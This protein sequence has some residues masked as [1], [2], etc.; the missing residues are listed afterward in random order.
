MFVSWI[1]TVRKPVAKTMAPQL[2]KTIKKENVSFRSLP[3]CAL[4]WSAREFSPDFFQ[5]FYSV[6]N[7]REECWFNYDITIVT[8]MLSFQAFPIEWDHNGPNIIGDSHETSDP[9]TQAVVIRL[10]PFRPNRVAYYVKILAYRARYWLLHDI[11]SPVE[12][13]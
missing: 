7:S 1:Y 12:M 6:W 3:T 4:P 10:L 2:P 13:M 8:R 5:T 11:M 9:N